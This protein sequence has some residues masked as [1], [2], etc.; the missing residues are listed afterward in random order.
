MNILNVLDYIKNLNSNILTILIAFPTVIIAIVK[1]LSHRNSKIVK[2]RIK[3]IQNELPFG[4]NDKA[5]DAYNEILNSNLYL[6]KKTKSLIFYNIGH[7][8]HKIS[9]TK[10][11]EENLKQTLLYYIKAKNC[12]P[13]Y[14]SFH[15]RFVSK[16]NK[17]ALCII[18][19]GISHVYNDYAIFRYTEQ[20]L[21]Q[22]ELAAKIAEDIAIDIKDNYQLALA[23]INLGMMYRSKFSQSKEIMDIDL[24]IQYSE[25][26]QLLITQSNSPYDYLIVINNLANA[27]RERGNYNKCVPDCNKAI[28]MLKDTLNS[29][30]EESFVF[31]HARSCMNL[32]ATYM[33]LGEITEAINYWNEAIKYNELARDLFTKYG[34]NFFASYCAYNIG[35]SYKVLF[36]NSIN[37]NYLNKAY[38]YGDQ[39]LQNIDETKDTNI[40]WSIYSFMLVITKEMYLSSKKY[41]YFDKS[42]NIYN[43]LRHH[44]SSTDNFKYI[45]Y[46]DMTIGQLYLDHFMMTKQQESID[47]ALR[48]LESVYIQ[49][50]LNNDNQILVLIEIAKIKTIFNDI[51]GLVVQVNLI[52]K[53]IQNEVNDLP[54]NE[55]DNFQTRLILNKNLINYLYTTRDIIFWIKE[56]CDKSIWCEE[57]DLLIHKIYS[58]LTGLK[59]VQLGIDEEEIKK[60]AQQMGIQLKETNGIIEIP[61]DVANKIGFDIPLV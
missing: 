51:D 26:S 17:C 53:T 3:S 30:D 58:K 15:W 45:P 60:I 56:V 46:I 57:K 24:S 42:I 59:N 20:Y 27:L 4:L 54:Q 22:A 40:I 23:Y 52:L 61:V 34:N 33:N 41:C 28:K 47:E 18:S 31:E 14:K 6:N 13:E 38:K 7:S 50:K 9:L 12:L 5:I 49:G 8:Y 48:L 19:N 35:V 43:K 44:Y 11:I 2:N 1:L 29:F 16:L 37:P 55:D 10:N 21:E 39:A 36:D 32:G 25:K